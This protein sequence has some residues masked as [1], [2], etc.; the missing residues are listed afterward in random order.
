MTAENRTFADHRS[1]TLPEE[2]LEGIEVIDDRFLELIDSNA[3]ISN[4][5]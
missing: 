4:I 3:K 1:Q 2:L 5:C